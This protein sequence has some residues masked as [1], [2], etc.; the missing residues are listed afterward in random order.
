MKRGNGVKKLAELGFAMTAIAVLIAGCG[1]GGGAA[2]TGSSTLS[3]V[4]ADGYLSGANVCLD[5]NSN[6]TCDAGEPSGTSAAS[7]VYSISVPAGQATGFPIVAEIPANAIDA[8]TGSAVSQSFT[9]VAPAGASF[10]SPLTTLVQQKVAAGATSAAADAAVL[11]LLGFATP[12]AAAASGISALDNYVAKKAS[13]VD[14]TNPH[15]RAHEAAKVVAA[16]FKQNKALLAT[17]AVAS[18]DLA[19]QAVL[20]TQAQSVLSAQYNAAAPATM[21]NQASAVS[22]V[23][24]A[25]TLN[26]AIA[27]TRA[28]LVPA[29]A[30]QAVNISFD[31]VNGASAVGTTGC[32]TPF[33]VGTAPASGA[34]PAGTLGTLQDLRF[35][36]SNLSLVDNNGNYVPVKLTE[37]ANQSRG[38][39]LLDF[40]TGTGTCP[41]ATGTAA[42]YTTLAGAVAPPAPGT[43]YV[44]IAFSVGVPQYSNDG[45]T[46]VVLLNHS[47]PT[48]VVANA[49]TGA[50]ATPLLLQNAAMAWAWQSGRKFTKIEFAASAV[51]PALVGVSTL[52]HL[53]STGCLANPALATTTL[54]S[55][56][57]SPNNMQVFI[58]TGFNPAVN[59]VALDLGALFSGVDLTT[60][61]TWM[62]GKAGMMAMDAP[63]YFN[64]FQID[65]TSGQPINGGAAQTLFVI[66]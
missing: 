64:K 54:V 53:G 33:T 66:K 63:Y 30:T 34:A 25:G 6:G 18:T 13:A 49:T 32:V 4:V 20:A 15:F 28:V 35:Y 55:P 45:A 57:G 41:A 8:D 37:N 48:Q 56:C 50:P 40:E 42:T 65:L 44:G 23:S 51:P 3:G 38:V 36:V 60:S 46:P 24:T 11:Q 47:D 61:R 14:Q 9:L 58:P 10:V 17:S 31:V 19:T 7:G 22:Y 16:V 43:T 12:A 1:G 27:R 26:G 21:F 29:A 59:K 39:A 2:S 5:V 52:V 62:S